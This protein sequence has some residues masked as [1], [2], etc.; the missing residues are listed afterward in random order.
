M[1]KLQSILTMAFLFVTATTTLLPQS[2]GSFVIEKSVIAGGG[3]RS[4]GGLFIVDGTIAESAAGVTSTG[5]AFQL[6]SGFWGAGAVTAVSGTVTG[7][8]TSPLGLVLRF[9]TV[10]LID[11]QGVRRTATTSSS[12]VYTFD[13]VSFGQ[14]YTMTATSKRYRFAPK[15]LSINTS[16][17]GLDF[18]G[19]E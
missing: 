4:T 1:R 9:L 11:P 18:V 19:L 17:T 14:T 13:N 6:G 2:G 7:R 3:G 5:G 8:V 15:I 16:L 12:G 10:A